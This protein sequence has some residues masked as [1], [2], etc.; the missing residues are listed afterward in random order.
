M[1][2]VIMIFILAVAGAAA[3]SADIIGRYSFN[4][5]ARDSVGTGE[6]RLQGTASIA[7]GALLLDGGG[8]A[9]LPAGWTAGKD[10]VAIEA[11]FTYR[12]NGDWVR[13][14]D[15]GVTNASG[16]G[17]RC[18][19][20]TPQYPGGS[21]TTFSNSDPGF[22]YE[23][24]IDAAPLPPDALTHVAVVFDSR[25]G[26]ARLFVEGRLAGERNLTVKLS[27]I[28]TDHLYLGKSSYASDNLMAGSISEFR[29]YDAPL[30]E[31]QVRL[32][33]QLGPDVFQDRG[34]Q[35]PVDEAANSRI[36]SEA[37][38]RSRVMQTLH[39]LTDLYGPRLSGS[40]N[41][42]SA[43]EW[44]AK[45]LAEWGLQNA[46]LEPWDFGHPGWSNE[47]ISGFVLSPIR[48]SLGIHAVAWTPSTKGSVKAPAVQVIPP[49]GATAEEM[50]AWL[51]ANAS[52]VRGKIVLVGAAADTTP[53]PEAKKP[54]EGPGGPGAVPQQ[55]PKS[56]PNILTAAQREEMIDSWLVSNGALVRLYDGALAN[57]A[58]GIFRNRTFDE[59]KA[60]P[61]AILRNDD[62]GRIERLLRDG[63]AVEMEFEIVNRWYPEGKT[64]YNVVAEIPGTDKAD[65]IVMLGAHLDSWNVATGAADDGAA[66]AMMMEAV[67]IIRQS[68]LQPRRTI[69]IGLWSA[70]E[71]G[72]LGSQAYVKAHFGSFENPKPEFGKILCY[73]NMDSGAGSVSRVMV[74]GPKEAELV[75]RDAIAPFGDLGAGG[76]S[77]FLSRALGST[78]SSSFSHAG[79]ATVDMMQH[80]GAYGATIHSSLD[81]YDRVAPADLIKGSTVI[82]AAVW[83]VANREEKLPLFTRE[84]MPAP[85]PDRKE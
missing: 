62:Y 21:R 72:L 42:K 56:D 38:D 5:D 85:V 67:R 48:A 40:P 82:A 65:E 9:E 15:F 68:G 11:W 3:A 50:S 34:T 12:P 31:A 76:S 71:Q 70:E 37:T 81:T 69:R 49:A 79:I 22:K 44:A 52:G 84:Q 10:C 73:F 18:W 80:P 1:K 64:N 28:G 13:V 36:R 30:D 74:F 41:Y 46:R 14:F 32:N 26:K 53:K 51:K 20:F 43:A 61:G 54:G 8:W 16:R 63:L 24:T 75:L 33:H 47:R 57:G 23:E 4:A 19:Y 55:R 6:A 2:K 17:A 83:N 66:A 78:D 45:R 60:L 27:E 59:T 25:A 35:E 29:I 7:D 58:V 39:I 77:A